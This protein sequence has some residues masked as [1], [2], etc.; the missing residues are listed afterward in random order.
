MPFHAGNPFDPLCFALLLRQVFGRLKK[1]SSIFSSLIFI[2]F[3]SNGILIFNHY[4][5]NR[6]G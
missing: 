3:G 6:N 1:L 4:Y 5:F 2:A